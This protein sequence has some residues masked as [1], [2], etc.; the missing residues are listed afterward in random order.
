MKLTEELEHCLSL[1]YTVKFERFINQIMITV[2]NKKGEDK[3]AA[4]PFDHLYESK[5]VDC[6]QYLRK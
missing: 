3:N 6:I 4:L 5:I 1:G 2:T